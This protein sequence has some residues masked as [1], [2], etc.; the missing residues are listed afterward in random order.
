MF[1]FLVKAVCDSYPRHK[2]LRSKSSSWYDAVEKKK[3]ED[4]RCH[5]SC[6]KD[7]FLCVRVCVYVNLFL[8]IS[9]V[10]NHM[11]THNVGSDNSMLKKI[12]SINQFRVKDLS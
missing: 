1:F 4:Q 11:L 5:C 8:Y 6:K 7:E 2:L 10:Q 3:V 9:W 12:N